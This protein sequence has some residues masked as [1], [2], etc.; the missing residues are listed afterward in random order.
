MAILNAE[1]AA[2]NQSR[3]LLQPVHKPP[4]FVRTIVPKGAVSRSIS[5]CLLPPH[6]ISR[7]CTSRNSP[8]SLKSCRQLVVCTSTSLQVFD[9]DDDTVSLRPLTDVMLFTSVLDIAAVSTPVPGRDVLVVLSAR[10]TISFM[11]FDDNTSRLRCAGQRSLDQLYLSELESSLRTHPRLLATHPRKRIVAVASLRSKIYVFPVIFLPKQVNAGKIAS[12]DVDGVILS[13]DF[14]ED[15]ND[16]SGDSILVALLQRRKHQLIALYSVSV[17][18]DSTRGLVVNLIGSMIT[19]AAHPD[20]VAVARATSKLTGQAVSPAPLAAAVTR[21]PACPFLFAV[22]VRGKVIAGDA[23]HVIANARSG[24]SVSVSVRIEDEAVVP[25]RPNHLDTDGGLQSSSPAADDESLPAPASPEL[26]NLDTAPRTPEMSTISRAGPSAEHSVLHTPTSAAAATS[27]DGFVTPV[28][29]PVTRREPP[30]APLQTCR[31]RRPGRDDIPMLPSLIKRPSSIAG[32]VPFTPTF[33]NIGEDY[34]S[35]LYVPAYISRDI[36]DVEGVA[37]AWVDA[38]DHFRDEDSDV[39]GLYFVLESG[40]LYALKWSTDAMDGAFTFCIPPTDCNRASPK[41]NFSVE[42]VGDIGPAVSIASLDRRLL[43]VAND[44]ADGSLRRLHL[45]HSAYVK[46]SLDNRTFTYLRQVS[47]RRDAGRY[48][49][50]VRQEFLNLSPISDFIIAPPRSL[51]FDRKRTN[52]TVAHDYPSSTNTFSWDVLDLAWR[53]DEERDQSALDYVLDGGQN[54]AEL[55]VCSGIGRYGSVRLIRPG[56]P[57]SVFASTD[58]SFFACNDMWAL[59]FTKNAVFDAAIALTFAQD[60]RLLLSVPVSPFEHTRATMTGSGPK[61][62]NL[63]DGTRA[64]ELVLGRRTIRIGLLEDGV[65]AQIHES[66]IRL[67][68][69]KKAGDIDMADYVS[70]GTLRESICDCTMDWVPPTGCFISVGTIGA[71]FILISVIQ[72]HSSPCVLYLLK[73]YPGD[74][75]LGLCVVSS[76]QL[77]YE[78]SCIEIPEWT[79]IHSDTDF[80]SPQLPPM[81]VLGTYEPSVEIRLLGPAMELLAKRRT[82]AWSLRYPSSLTRKGSGTTGGRVSSH[83]SPSGMSDNV[84]IEN[85]V[86][87]SLEVMTAVPESICALEI[88][89]KRLIFTGLR[90]GSVLLFC[91]DERGNASKA[92]S[93][94]PNAGANLLIASHRK[95]G[96]R[97]VVVKSVTCAIGQVVIGQAERPWMCVGIGGGKVNWT[98]LAFTETRAICSYSVPGAERCFATAGADNAF[99]ICGLRRRSQ[100]SV[101]SIHVGATPRRVISVSYPQESIVVATSGD[102]TA[103]RSLNHA[104]MHREYLSGH[105]CEESS[106]LSP[107]RSELLLYKRRG[108]DLLGCL[109]LMQWELVHVLM[110]WM[111]F[112]VVGTSLGSQSYCDSGSGKLGKHGRLLL[113]MI[114]GSDGAGSSTAPSS[115]KFELCSEVILPGAVLTGCVSAKDDILIVSCNTEV[116]VFTL[117]Q[118]RSVLVEVAR[119]SARTLVVGLSIKDD[120]VCIVDRKDSIGFFQLKAKAGRL[121]RDRSDHTRRIVS[122]AALVDRTLALAVDRYGGLFSIG[123]EDGDDPPPMDRGLR[124]A[125]KS[126]LLASSQRRGIRSHRFSDALFH[127]TLSDCEPTGETGY[128]SLDSDSDRSA[129]SIDVG[130]ID[131]ERLGEGAENRGPNSMEGVTASAVDSGHVTGANDDTENMESDEGQEGVMDPE[132][133]VADEISNAELM[134]DDETDEEDYENRNRR[135]G[136]I[137]RNLVSHHSYNL[138]DTALHIRIGTFSR[139]EK[140]SDMEMDENLELSCAAGFFTSHSAAAICGTL[141]GAIVS[142]VGMSTDSFALLSA[143]EEGMGMH[144]DIAEPALGSSHKKLRATYGQQAVGTVDGDLLSLFEGLADYTKQEIAARVGLA[145]EHGVLLIE[146]MIRDLCDRVA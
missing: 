57:V 101:R 78:L 36:A 38:R 95:I 126:P 130:E 30:S 131:I 74:P 102:V 43:F 51:H 15:D 75:S 6:A 129:E 37:T 146:G 25:P 45:P 24:D 72:Q 138:R 121:I 94:S 55:I 16:S 28:Q 82:C 125:T 90:D 27:N 79:V 84:V 117:I 66:G 33:R 107:K 83:R 88:D 133:N 8:P 124:V 67:V 87:A 4:L 22:F 29:T 123:Y 77:N 42:Y 99:Y 48:G 108:R 41:R 80:L 12:V 98:P 111:D 81:A 145:G 13:I 104:I 141:G 46:R 70:N 1:S 59:R 115:M 109:P 136:S 3:P 86:S 143:V 20:D 112:V 73:C 76:S 89:G 14:L 17:S 144:P 68:F 69:L 60:T 122:D 32:G 114:C 64:S 96:H 2:H 49:L 19:C 100:V 140:V 5:C 120:I 116:L 11:Q 85:S 106:I 34:L 92:D 105:D 47:G 142:A 23:R 31:T 132:V 39:S 139:A 97:P 110:N 53:A 56:A 65:I 113:F 91:L 134:D 63:I 103:T 127:Q 137:P 61:I 52:Q 54:E 71:G 40:A 135:T 10:D 9:V 35:Y 18:P 7:G 26:N 21:L 44:G 128:A 93:G 62:A 118:E 119:V 50:E 58:R